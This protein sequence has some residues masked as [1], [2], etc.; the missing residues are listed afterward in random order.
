MEFFNNIIRNQVSQTRIRYK[1]D[2]YDLDLTYI[3]PKI[4]AMSFPA[5][6][7][8][9]KLY[10]N[11]IEVVAKFLEEKHAGNYRIY[12]LTGKDY[13][14]T[15]FKKKVVTYQWEDHH[16]PTLYLLSQCCQDIHDFLEENRNNVI[17]VH[18]NAGKGRTGTLIACYLLFCGFCDTARDALAYYGFKRF[19]DGTGVENPS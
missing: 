2:E 5:E 15:A 18:C 19:T 7:F 8:V 4:M 13:D 17:I 14:M 3:T 6:A 12:N 9:Q 1:D 16:S 11:N 10:R